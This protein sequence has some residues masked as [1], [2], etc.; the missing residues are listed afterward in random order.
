MRTGMIFSAERMKI[1]EA[2]AEIRSSVRPMPEL[3]AHAGSGSKFLF[4]N[5]KPLDLLDNAPRGAT[6]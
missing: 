2:R 3:A 5:G 4:G 1:L 6:R